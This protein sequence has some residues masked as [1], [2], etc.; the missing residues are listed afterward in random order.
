MW[1][2]EHDGR[3][4]KEGITKMH[5]EERKDNLNYIVAHKKK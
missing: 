2:K 3:V 4:N 5:L 1:E